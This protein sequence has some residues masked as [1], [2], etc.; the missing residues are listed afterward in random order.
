M[1]NELEE[2]N[3]LFQ[4]WLEMGYN[5]RVHGSLGC[6]PIQKWLAS[7]EKIRMLKSNRVN[8]VFRFSEERRVRKDGTFSLKRV[9]YETSWILSGKQ[10]R[11]L[12]DPLTMKDIEVFH[13]GI[14]YGRALPLK[15]NINY[16]LPRAGGG[17]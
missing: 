9:Y 3:S 1:P 8:D 11:I 4:R 17:K 7:A 5:N 13:Q 16:S 12:Y 6:T 15:R 14:S 10:I 2:L